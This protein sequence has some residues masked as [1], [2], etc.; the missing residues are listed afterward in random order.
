MEVGM[1]Y[2]VKPIV[3][4]LPQYHRVKENEQWWGKGFTDWVAVKKACKLYDGHVQPNVPLNDN[5]YN[6]LDKDVMK[7]QAEIAYK[8]GIYGFSFYHYWFKDGRKILEKPA[9]NLLKWTDIRV[10]FCF[11]WANES[12]ARSWSNISN[13]NTWADTF[14]KQQG[15][16]GSSVFFE[17]LI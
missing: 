8:Y 1:M 4:Y 13:H 12:W 17:L 6:L 16:H 3:M 5:Y 15:V 2:K 10:P 7:W 14:E 9:E 11:T